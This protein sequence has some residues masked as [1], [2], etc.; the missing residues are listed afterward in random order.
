MEDEI[1]RNVAILG[2]KTK[3][4][5]AKNPSV[6]TIN[7]HGVPVNCGIVSTRPPA[8]ESGGEKDRTKALVNV[9]AFSCNFR[10]QALILTASRK[11]PENSF[12]TIGSDFVGEVIA[13][14]EDVEGFSVGDKVIG[15]YSYIG[16]QFVETSYRQGVTTNHSSTEYQA[17]DAN[18]IVK[19][20]S[21]MPNEV[22]GAFSVN[23]QT[24]YSIVRKLEVKEGDNILVTAA[25]SH[26]SMFAINGLRK[27][28]A[29][30]YALTTSRGYEEKFARLG[31]K[32]VLQ[33]DSQLKY[34]AEDPR[35]LEVALTIG[36][37]DHVID[38]FYDVYLPK[39]V[40]VMAPGGKYISCGFWSQYHHLTD[41]K[42]P[43]PNLRL[44]Q[45]LGYSIANNLQILF[46]CLGDTNDLQNAIDDYAAGGLD[47]VIDSVHTGNE[48][49][50]F[51]TRAYMAPDRF[52]KVVYQYN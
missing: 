39:V 2:N 45:A 43:D 20:P 49:G 40:Y 37:F 28:K 21:A 27:Y 16:A 7:L 52:G 42:T 17:F 25:R 12:Y 14:G 19:V 26:T 3:E 11:G 10:D 9:K 33:V 44:H 51:L 24:A 47:V 34:L 13:V 15:D 46:N 4:L 50:A 6:S 1:M 48:V 8:F 18:K 22:A 36:G 41:E 32:D 23:A 38:P 31:V 35:V 5:L 30:V 29:N